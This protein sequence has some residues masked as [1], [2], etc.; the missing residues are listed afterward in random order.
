MRWMNRK[1]EPVEAQPHHSSNLIPDCVDKM[2]CM[3]GLYCKIL[4]ELN[5]PKASSVPLGSRENVHT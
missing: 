1:S 4:S 5:R 3:L 2:T